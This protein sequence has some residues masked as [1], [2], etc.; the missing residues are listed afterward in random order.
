[1]QYAHLPAFFTEPEVT[2]V[3]DFIALGALPLVE[4]DVAVNVRQP[5]TAA[6]RAIFLFVL[7]GNEE[8]HQIHLLVNA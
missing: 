6:T 7:H 4:Q 3:V 5:V 1:M 2:P 8:A